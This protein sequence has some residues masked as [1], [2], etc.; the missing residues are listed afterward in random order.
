MITLFNYLGLFGDENMKSEGQ[1]SS[2]TSASASSDSAISI[3][4]NEDMS[5][6]SSAS[7]SNNSGAADQMSLQD[8]LQQLQSFGFSLQE[9]TQSLQQAAGD[10]N[11]AA[12][13]LLSSR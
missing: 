7:S 6:S 3:S 1:S 4:N 11:L 12:T 13:L 9:S 2:S 10:V 5:S 8:K